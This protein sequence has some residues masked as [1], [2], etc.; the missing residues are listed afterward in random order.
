[1]VWKKSRIG[2]RI[3]AAQSLVPNST[4]SGSPTTSTI[5]TDTAVT[6]SRSI[7]SSQ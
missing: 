6:M 3:R 2:V 7:E 4:A 1:M 5:T